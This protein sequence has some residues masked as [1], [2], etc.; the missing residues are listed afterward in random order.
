MSDNPMH[1]ISDLNWQEN[2][3]DMHDCG[4]AL[5]HGFLLPGLM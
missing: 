2:A 3:E 1:Q 4:Y 5:I